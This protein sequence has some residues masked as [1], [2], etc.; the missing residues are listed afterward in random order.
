MVEKVT[1]TNLSTGKASTQC[2]RLVKTDVEESAEVEGEAASALAGFGT[3]LDEVQGV[4]F[5]NHSR[6]VIL[7][8]NTHKVNGF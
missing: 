5:G 6:I 3:Q 7:N 8:L 4:P 2:I 1:I